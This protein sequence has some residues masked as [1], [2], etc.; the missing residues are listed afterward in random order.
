MLGVGYVGSPPLAS[1][2]SDHKPTAKIIASQAG[3]ATAKYQVIRSS[4]DPISTGLRFPLVVKPVTGMCSCRVYRVT[5]GAELRSRV[6]SLVAR[7]HSEVLVEEFIQGRDITVGVLQLE[8]KI[9]TLC[10]LE[11]CFAWDDEALFSDPRYKRA[12]PESTLAESHPISHT[13]EP[14]LDATV[15]MAARKVFLALGLRH[16]ARVDFRLAD[17]TFYFLEANH[18]PDL[19]TSSL[20]AHSAAL[21]GIDY[22]GLIGKILA[23]AKR[24]AST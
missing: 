16:V 21:S 10:P 20:V 18:K 8:G 17:E 2:M 14:N 4:G 23:E 19:T 24:D 3:V 1:A 11:R 15:Q 6:E 5:N 13:L 9:V 7:Y 12:H 22:N